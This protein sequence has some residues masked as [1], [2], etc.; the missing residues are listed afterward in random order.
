MKG[1]VLFLS[2]NWKKFVNSPQWF[3]AELYAKL[4]IVEA[5]EVVT[6]KF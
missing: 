6:L 1:I 3:V 4:L 2:S 5:I